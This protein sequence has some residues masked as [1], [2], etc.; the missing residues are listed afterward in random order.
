M[1]VL[2]TGAAGFIGQ[3][4]VRELASRGHSVRGAD[5]NPMDD[6]PLA[7][8]VVGDLAEPSVAQAAVTDVEFVYHLAASRGDFG[9]SAEQYHHDNV[10]ATRS[11]LMAGADEGVSDWIFYSSVSA[12]G[13]SSVVRDETADLSPTIP[14]GRTKAQAETLFHEFAAEQPTARVTVVR[15]SVVYG[16]ENPPD[17]NIYRLIEAI[18]GGRFAM[19]GDGETLKTTSYIENLIDA[20]FFLSDRMSDEVQTF[21]YVDEPVLSTGELVERIHRLLGVSPPSWSIPLSVARPVASVSDLIAEIT[22]IDF[23]ITAA[24]I[25]KFCTPTL[26]DGRAIREFGFEQPVSNEEALRKTVEWHRT[27]NGCG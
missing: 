7:D 10:E 13:P 19:V 8:A 11:L 18:D 21:I 6:L 5:R 16:P 9:I 20:T 15:P 3:V 27:K 24:R 1:R 22:G 17:T 14:Y 26:F 23:P 4:L 12:M 25:E 2:V